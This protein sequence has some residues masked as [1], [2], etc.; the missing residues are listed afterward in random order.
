M[1]IKGSSLINQYVKRKLIKILPL[2]CK[3]NIN[4][5]VIVC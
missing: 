3:R 2:I 4:G 5:Q 1:W